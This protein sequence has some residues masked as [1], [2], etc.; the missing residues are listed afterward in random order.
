MKKIVSAFLLALLLTTTVLGSEFFA[1]NASVQVCSDY[2]N[3]KYKEDVH[4]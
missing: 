2:K 4:A 3:D 1:D